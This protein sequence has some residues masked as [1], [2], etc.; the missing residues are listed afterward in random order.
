M[1]AIIVFR[2]HQRRLYIDRQSGLS[3]DD[4]LAAIERSSSVY[5]GRYPFTGTN[6]VRE[7]QISTVFFRSAVRSN[8]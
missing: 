8:A 4:Y 5:V 2:E 6:A 7:A 1:S 3:D